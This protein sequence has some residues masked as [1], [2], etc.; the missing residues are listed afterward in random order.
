MSVSVTTTP[1]F[2]WSKPTM[3]FEGPYL[4]DYDVLPDGSRFLTI[5]ESGQ[6][7]GVT[8][9]NVVANWLQELGGRK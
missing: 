4:S 5:K 6:N 8:H 2:S 1:A 3:L 9:F 7:R